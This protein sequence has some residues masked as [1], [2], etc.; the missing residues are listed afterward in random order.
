MDGSSLLLEANATS[1][2]MFSR[3][4]NGS[5]TELV[6]WET[7][8]G[9]LMRRRG[10][11]LGVDGRVPAGGWH[12][13]DHKTMLE[14]VGSGT[15]FRFFAGSRSLAAPLSATDLLVVDRVELTASRPGRWGTE[16][17]VVLCVAGVG[18]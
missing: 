6:A 3:A 1:V 7:S 13:T 18:R 11:V 16:A 5:A 17:T 4:G 14:S 12:F 2:V 9:R 10:E 15:V 8:S